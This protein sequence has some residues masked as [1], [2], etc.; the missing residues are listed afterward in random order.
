[1]ILPIQLRV[2]ALI[3]LAATPSNAADWAL[4]PGE[5]V[6]HPGIAMASLVFEG[7]R[8]AKGDLVV[9]LYGD[10][11]E[12]FLAKGKKLAKL[13]LPARAGETRACLTVPVPGIYAISVF[14]DEDRSG[15]LNRG[16]LGAPTEG[17]GF[18]NSPESLLAPPSFEKV[19][20]NLAAGVTAVRIVMH[21]P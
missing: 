19:A 16:F 5:C 13:N 8:S 10:C 9:T 12:D 2:L 6:P 11:P 3:L 21:Y 14:H 18:P 17:Y 4:A 7:V 20:I 1:M 15:R